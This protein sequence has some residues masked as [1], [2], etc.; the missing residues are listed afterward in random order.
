MNKPLAVLF[1]LFIHTVSIAQTVGINGVVTDTSD[2]PIRSAAV[3][4][5]QDGIVVQGTI[6]KADGSFALEAVKGRYA[7]T[8]SCIG[9]EIWSAD[10]A[11][12]ADTVL[13]KIMLSAGIDID[14]V[15]ITAS[16]RGASPTAGGLV[17]AVSERDVKNSINSYQLLSKVPGLQVNRADRSIGVV[18]SSSTLIMVN[19]VRREPIVVQSINPSDIVRV[20]V[21]SNPSVK[22]LSEDITSVVN[23]ITIDRV[24]G[25]SGEI[26][27]MV[28]V[29]NLKTDGWTDLSI[30]GNTDKMSIYMVGYFN[31]GNE[32]RIKRR[33]T[34]HTFASGNK[35]TFES[36]SDTCAE[37]DF[38]G[39]EINAGADFKLAPRTS[40]T[41]DAYYKHDASVQDRITHRQMILNDVYVRYDRIDYNENDKERQHKYSAYFQRLHADSCGQFDIELSYIDYFY[42]NNARNLITSSIGSSSYML[43]S[44]SRQQALHCQAE[45][46]YEV[47]GGNLTVGYRLRYQRIAQGVNDVM[48]GGAEDVKY[49]EFKHYP[50]LYYAGA[51][52]R[53]F[54]CRLGIGTEFTS[55]QFIPIGHTSTGN[56]YVKLLPSMSM[57]YATPS[58]GALGAYYG[59]SL[60]RVE[61]QQL[62]PT[63][64]SLDSLSFRQGNPRL[65][66]YLYHNVGLRY[67]LSKGSFYFYSQLNYRWARNS[68]VSMVEVL[69]H[70]VSRHTYSP[71]AFYNLLRPMIYSKWSISDVWELYG[72]LGYSMCKY[73]DK[74]N[75]INTNLSSF[76][77]DAGGTCYLRR[78]YH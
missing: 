42:T 26:A 28:T 71:A 37:N 75:Q 38:P 33:E 25:L 70:G 73:E 78:F 6:T 59:A 58:V 45:Y 68:I 51:V 77:W 63:T 69:P 29:P 54:S 61:I 9:Y 17:Y 13:N 35:F 10:I 41:I 46:G 3:V 5:V 67:T 19:G 36:V 49:T 24:R 27:Q 40:L 18:G 30:T 52:G 64:I 7:I 22:Y 47:W 1:L 65:E 8:V 66:P 50:Y 55:F 39:I 31:Y 23:I 43:Q 62:N 57:Q 60:Q 14:E 20:E 32:N 4:L 11:F 21:I 48:D 44:Q 15:A 53:H 2:M 12:N 76:D 34:T 72:S 74:T 56:Q 16:R